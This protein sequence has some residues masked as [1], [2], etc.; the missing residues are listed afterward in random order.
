VK[1]ERK[2]RDRERDAREH[3]PEIREKARSFV[4][5]TTARLQKL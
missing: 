5:L 1:E 3:V 4:W 2:E